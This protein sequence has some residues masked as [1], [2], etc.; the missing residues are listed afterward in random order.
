MKEILTKFST[1]RRIKTSYRYERYLDI[2]FHYKAGQN[3]VT[4]QYE[5]DFEM[6]YYFKVAQ[7]LVADHYERGYVDWLYSI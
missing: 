7:N 2:I 4:E 5:R 3:L 1:L 6:I